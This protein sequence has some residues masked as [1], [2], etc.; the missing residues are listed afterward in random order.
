MKLAHQKRI[1]RYGTMIHFIILAKQLFRDDWHQYGSPRIR[2]LLWDAIS[3]NVFI[4]ARSGEFIELIA[5]ASSGRGLY[6]R[7]VALVVLINENCNT[8][9]A[10]RGREGCKGHDIH[11]W[12]ETTT[13]T[14]GRIGLAST[15]LQPH[16]FPH[17]HYLGYEGP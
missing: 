13:L 11:S 1:R 17:R 6:F 10:V 9:F 5:R 7:D 14:S 8:E 15:L 12:Q 3:H 2:I 4:S 16:A